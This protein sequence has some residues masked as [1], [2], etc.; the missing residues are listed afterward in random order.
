MNINK[1]PLD[2]TTG[3]LQTVLRAL[4]VSF[5]PQQQDDEE[6]ANSYVYYGDEADCQG[7]F[8]SS[9]SHGSGSRFEGMMA[10]GKSFLSSSGTQAL[11][12]MHSASSFLNGE[13][14]DFTSTCC[15]AL[16]LKKRLFF[17]SCCFAL[18][19][20]LQFCSFGAVAGIF[21]GHAGRFAFLYTL[22]NIT[23]LAAT[24]FLAGPAAQ[25]RRS[26]T[27]GRCT[28]F[29]LFL[30]TMVLT[31]GLVFSQPFLGRG[32][33]ILLCVGVQWCALVWYILSFVPYG[34][35]CGRHVLGFLSGCLLRR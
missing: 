29:M 32:L 6:A 11:G 9:A 34:H 8:G 25:W 20:M 28:T 16:G 13:E 21:F 2:F 18:G 22:S 35:R 31:L 19:Q 23:M 17:C 7:G 24:F 30:S 27:K 4:P 3:A 33:L 12:A 1:Q 14:D 10:G 15:P 26:S 5:A